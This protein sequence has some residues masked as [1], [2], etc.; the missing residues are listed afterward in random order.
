MQFWFGVVAGLFTGWIFDYFFGW[1]PRRSPSQTP[2]SIPS[3]SD[4]PFQESD[5]E[6]NA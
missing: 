6:N 4:S 1:R 2:D 5:G 3:H